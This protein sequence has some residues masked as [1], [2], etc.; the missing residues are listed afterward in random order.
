M[1]VAYTYDFLLFLFRVLWRGICA[2]RIIWKESIHLLITIW[3]PNDIHW[4]LRFSGFWCWVWVEAWKPRWAV[5]SSLSHSTLLPRKQTSIYLSK[6]ERGWGAGTDGSGQWDQVQSRTACVTDDRS[7]CLYDQETKRLCMAYICPLK[8]KYFTFF[9]T[10]NGSEPAHRTVSSL[11]AE[12]LLIQVGPNIRHADTYLELH[13]SVITLQWRKRKVKGW[14]DA[15]HPCK[16][17]W[18]WECRGRNIHPLLK[19]ESIFYA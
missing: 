3:R 2:K 11:N 4:T 17:C 19:I 1:T 18:K 8:A 16:L 15:S 9:A 13:L 10:D 5:Y 12:F 7:L 14:K 6:K